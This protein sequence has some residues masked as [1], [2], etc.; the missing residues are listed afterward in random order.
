M[1]LKNFY[2][3]KN[4]IEHI[5]CNGGQVTV[6]CN[7]GQTVVIDPGV[8]GRKPSANSWVQYTLAPYI[9][10]T[11]GRH[12]IDKLIIMKPGIRIFEAIETLC[13]TMQINTI[14][15]VSWDGTL[16]KN[17]WRAFFHFKRAAQEQGIRFARIG[18]RKLIIP[19]DL[20]N[21]ITIEPTNSTFKY[22]DAT[23]PTL[24]IS[25]QINNQMFTI[26]SAGYKGILEKK[27]V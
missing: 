9:T 11:T 7:K 21:K 25:G 22:H 5:D 16:K 2:C 4:L 17:G 3:S 8:I 27:E 6:I 13:R 18:K 24:H 1:L 15:L 14:F 12:A 20:D 10:T 23:Y 19:I 26:Y